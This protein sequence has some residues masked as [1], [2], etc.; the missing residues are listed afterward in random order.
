MEQNNYSFCVK[1]ITKR[2]VLD[3]LKILTKK[4]SSVNFIHRNFNNS[5]F[6]SK[7]PIDLRKADVIPVHK[8]KVKT[9]IAN[10]RPISILPTL[11]KIYET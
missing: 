1:Y 9:S 11:S 2:K 7:F 10:Y 8:K 5:L 3:I 6:I 4:T